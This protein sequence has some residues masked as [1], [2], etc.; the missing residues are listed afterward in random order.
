MNIGKVIQVAGP[1][2]DVEFSGPLPAIY[3]ALKCDYPV[4]GQPQSL[5]LEVQQHLGDRW[6][7]TLSMSGTEASS[8]ATR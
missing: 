3:N 1:V 4:D 5:T 8:A 6:V 2:V 7:R